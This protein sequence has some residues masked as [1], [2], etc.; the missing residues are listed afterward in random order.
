[1]SKK[2]KR[3]ARHA[4]TET[5]QPSGQAPAVPTRAAEFNPDYTFVIKD[6]RRIGAL[7]GTFILI[8]IVLT[9]FLR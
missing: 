9:F 8:L 4:R 5:A 7:A 6:L 1:M 3:Q 2:N